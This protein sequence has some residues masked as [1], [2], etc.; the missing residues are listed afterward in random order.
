MLMY[1]LKV[2]LHQHWENLHVVGFTYRISINCHQKVFSFGY[3]IYWAKY[4]PFISNTWWATPCYC[5]LS[6]LFWFVRQWILLTGTDF[7]QRFKQISIALLFI[8]SHIMG[9]GTNVPSSDKD[10][11]WILKHAW[12]YCALPLRL[13]FQLIATCLEISAISHQTIC[14]IHTLEL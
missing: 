7:A 5:T 12:C 13:L 3:K 2:K 9:S 1:Q 6:G 8:T 10:M 4:T 14:I 11:F